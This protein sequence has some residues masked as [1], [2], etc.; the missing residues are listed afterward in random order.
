[1]KHKIIIKTLFSIFFLLL[2]IVCFSQQS[3]AA[4]KFVRKY[5]KNID[6]SHSQTEVTVGRYKI[7]ADMSRPALPFREIVFR[8]HIE[9]DGRPVE[10]K[11][12]DVKFNMVMD[13]GLYKARLQKAATGYTAKITLPKCIF[14]GQRWFAKL[15]FEEGNFSAEKVFLFD[16]DEK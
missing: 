14:G 4:E 12:G 1:M 3:F 5:Q 2:L 16:M 10:L 9:R 11:S 8:F 13:M 15:E 6:L 7:K